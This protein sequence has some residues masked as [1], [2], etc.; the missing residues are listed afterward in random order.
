MYLSSVY[1]V[2]E[3]FGK[4]LAFYQKLLQVPPGSVHDDRFAVF[5]SEGTTFSLLNAH[6][7]HEHPERIVRRGMNPQQF[8]DYP[9]IASAKNAHKVVLNFWTKDLRMEHARLLA[10]GLAAEISPIQYLRARAPYYFFVLT[11]PDDNLIEVAGEYEPMPGE[12]DL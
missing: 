10:L 11:D 2:V 8:P 3:D 12:F 4:S 1:L 5:V 9:A 7:D 6:Y